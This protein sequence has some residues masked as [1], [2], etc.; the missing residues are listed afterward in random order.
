MARR[1]LTLTLNITLDED[2]CRE[3]EDPQALFNLTEDLDY[4]R[5]TISA[6]AGRILHHWDPHLSDPELHRTGITY[7][8][9]HPLDDAI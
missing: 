5:T 9:A 1:H 8:P 4:L 6:E 7:E 2:L 3:S